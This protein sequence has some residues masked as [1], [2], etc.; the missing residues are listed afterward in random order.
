MTYTCCERNA[1]R[2]DRSVGKTRA[3]QPLLS[4]SSPEPLYRQLANHLEGEILG[5]RLKPG[6]RL[7][8]EGLLTDR[9]QV[10]R[11]TLRQAVAELVR[12]R[13]LV[14]QQGKGTFVTAPAVRHDLR[15][16]HG[17]LGSLFSQAE[18][19]SARLLRYEL[20]VPPAE[21][22]T[23]LDLGPQRPALRLDR[24]YLIDGKPVALAEAWLVSEVGALSST[25]ANLMSTE[26]MMRQVGI[27]IA[28]SEV[29]MRAEAAGAAVGRALNI[30]A[31]AAVLVLR[32]RT[33]ADDGAVKEVCRVWFCSDAYEFV[34]SAGPTVGAGSLFDI[35]DVGS[36]FDIPATRSDEHE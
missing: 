25:T 31:R 3:A 16:A 13:L 28:S 2:K 6:D 23:L 33:L 24:L 5:G 36:G 27:A 17:L 29:T 4:R 18:G 35:R 32:R 19:A 8:S 30:S 20:Q 34:C 9:F 14:R 15:R 21:T 12:K 26:D 7:A 1:N 10:S 22:A 11:I